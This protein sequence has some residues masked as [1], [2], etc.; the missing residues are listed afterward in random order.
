ME[1][2]LIGVKESSLLKLSIILH[3]FIHLRVFSD[4]INP[5]SMTLF[6]CVNVFQSIKL[7]LKHKED[8]LTL[9]IC[10]LA[11]VLVYIQ[12]AAANLNEIV[13]LDKSLARSIR[14]FRHFT[15]EVTL[16]VRNDLL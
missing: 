12:I 16:I 5:S 14:V 10:F 3:D 6:L 4:I 8:D 9:C 15:Y 7:L 1:P 13:L 11:I 2:I